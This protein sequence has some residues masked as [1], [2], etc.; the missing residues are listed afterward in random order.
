MVA[1]SV[2]RRVYDSGTPLGVDV[3]APLGRAIVIQPKYLKATYLADSETLLRETRA[4]GLFFFPGPV[5]SLLILLGL[6]YSALSATRSWPPF[7]GLTNAFG[8]IDSYSATAVTYLT[9]FFLFLTVIVLLWLLVRYL[10]WISTV[11]AVTTQRVIIQSGIVGRD[12]DEIPV[13]QVRGVDVKQSAGQRMLRYG[14]VWVSSE[15]GGTH[16]VGNEAWNGIPKP[17]EFQRIIQS[18]ASNLT[19]RNMAPYPP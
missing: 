19:R 3:V 5:I 15:G 7:P 8:R 2:S 18:A 13:Q 6:D 1:R 11:Y 12:F 9:Y 17:F 14:T 10:R 4:T 16:G